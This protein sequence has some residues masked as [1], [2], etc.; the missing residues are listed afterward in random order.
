MITLRSALFNLVFFLVTFVLTMAATVVRWVAPQHLLGVAM[1]WAR[2]IVAC[3]NS[4]CGIRVEVTG[5]ERIPEGT[6]LIASRHQSAFDT[7]VWMTLL[8]RCCYVVKQE[9]LRIPLFGKVIIGSGMI[10]IDRTSGV[11]ALAART[12]LP[13]IPVATDSGKC[14]GR[15]AF[16]KRPGVI[17]I[18]IGEPIPPTL[19]RHEL[20]LSLRAAIAALD[21]APAP[22]NRGKST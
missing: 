18:M 8:P 16:R 6:A 22:A 2:V 20:M 4:I 5:L 19:G 21:E 1:L 15:R 7:L 13:I 10:V 12:K 9:L 11:T 3:A 14:W 17:R